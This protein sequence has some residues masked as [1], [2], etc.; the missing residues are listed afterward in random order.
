VNT[1]T[2]LDG[3]SLLHELKSVPD[4]L[5]EGL[6][7]DAVDLKQLMPELKLPGKVRDQMH[8]CEV[9]AVMS[10]R[11]CQSRHS[12]IARVHFF[13]EKCRAQHGARQR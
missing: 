8:N 7:G 6:L 11:A 3:V 13:T 12:N 5:A 10:G 4:L 2:Y 1:R 9:N